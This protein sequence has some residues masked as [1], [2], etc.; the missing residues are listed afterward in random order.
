MLIESNY[1]SV[2]MPSCV[3]LDFSGRDRELTNAGCSTTDAVTNAT[4][5]NFSKLDEITKKILLA[6]L[7]LLVYG[8]HNIPGKNTFHNIPVFFTH[9]L[10][11]GSSY[12]L[13]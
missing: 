12:K 4:P 10:N 2:Y 5:F 11:E 13:N 6:T 7:I 8:F 3:F 1:V 9:K